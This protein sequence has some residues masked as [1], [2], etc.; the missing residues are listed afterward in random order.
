MEWMKKPEILNKQIL[1][2]LLHNSVYMVNEKNNN[3]LGFILHGS[4]ANE[5]IQNKKQSSKNSDV[6]IITIIKNKDKNASEELANVLWQKVGPKYDILV[7]TGSWGPLDW[8]EVIKAGNSE[9]E[10]EILKKNWNHLDSSVVIVGVNPEIENLIRKA[11][12]E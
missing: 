12:F 8:E 1:T 10:K 3:A 11:L 9:L 7:D 6:D 5:G 4:R 2:E